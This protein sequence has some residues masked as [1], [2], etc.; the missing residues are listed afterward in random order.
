MFLD[1]ITG[2]VT[3]KHGL[4]DKDRGA[5]YGYYNN[6]LNETGWSILEIHAQCSLC[7]NTDL[8]FAAG[9]FEGVVTAKCVII[10]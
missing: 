7:K 10:V 3:Y 2:A 9:F 5:V 1:P 8:M 4:M 6:T